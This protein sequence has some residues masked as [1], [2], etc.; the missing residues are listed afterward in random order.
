MRRD[1]NVSIAI[2]HYI[3]AK[4]MGPTC[5]LDFEY[6]LEIL[7]NI[8]NA[9]QA[10]HTTHATKKHTICCFTICKSSLLSQ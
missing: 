7:A 10:T 8:I 5:K 2:K 6:F 4:N 9:T 1:V 3:I